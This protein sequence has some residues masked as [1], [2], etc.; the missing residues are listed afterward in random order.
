MLQKAHCK[1]SLIWFWC[2]EEKP[3]IGQRDKE[4]NRKNER[5]DLGFSHI[6]CGLSDDI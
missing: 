1:R 4:E 5:K 6:R 2:E 3:N